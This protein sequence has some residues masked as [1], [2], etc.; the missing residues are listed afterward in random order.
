MPLTPR[1]RRTIRL[2]VLAVLVALA[3]GGV[4]YVAVVPPAE[5]SF[6]PKCWL[7]S[8]TG[9]H[10]P[11]C[12]LTRSL[13]AL[14]NGQVV[15]A[16]AYHPLA[17]LVLP[18]LFVVVTR[19]LWEWAWGTPPRPAR[20]RRTPRWLAVT[21]AVLVVA[22]AVARNIPAY[23]FTLLAPH[24]LAPPDDLGSSGK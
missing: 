2:G 21:F 11:G 20:P 4:L 16:L 13:H 9:L 18:Y 8:F 10:C 23:P 12:G 14:L 15:Q 22:F 17:L 6:L 1:Q 19:G 3:A 24:D 5:S 7:H